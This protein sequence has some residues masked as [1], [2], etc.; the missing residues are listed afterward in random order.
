MTAA[1]SDALY[2]GYIM[3][4]RFMPRPHAFRYGL[5]QLYLDIR[6]IEATLARFPFCSIGRFNWL[7]YRRADY[8]GNPSLSLDEAVRRHAESETGRAQHG[9]IFMLAHLRVLGLM[10]NPVSFYYGFDEDGR[11]LRWILAEI[12]NT[13]WGERFSYFLPVE[14]GHDVRHPATWRF[15]KR[16]HVSPFLPMAL[17]YDWRFGAPG[18]ALGVYMRVEQDGRRQFDATLT[19]RRRELKPSILLQQLL[20]FPWITAKV[21]AGIYW[22]ALLLWLKRVPFHDHP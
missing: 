11:T 6:R 9:P 21:A 4:R 17:A 15:P 14:A 5:F 12:T 10:M 3:H 13:P 1:Q 18:E 7:Q 16:F 2:V 8:F 22:N 20:S 19:L